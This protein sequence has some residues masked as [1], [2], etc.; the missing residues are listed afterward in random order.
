MAPRT[1][2]NGK[3]VLL[4]LLYAPSVRGEPQ[5]VK[6]RTRLTKMM[7]LFEKEVYDAFRFDCE[8]LREKLPTFY[9]WNY[10][11][12]SRDVYADIDFFVHV[13]FV[14]TTQCSDEQPLREEA[15]EYQLWQSDLDPP[16]STMAVTEYA[17]ELI[18][19][20]DMGRHYVK[21][22]ELWTRLSEN[23]KAALVEFKRRFTEAPLFAILRYVYERYPRMTAK[24]AIREK[25]MGPGSEF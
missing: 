1:A 25:V 18:A 21:Q 2:L 11:P 12:F 17:E 10:G 4:L 13:G 20:T 7:F 19:L 24:S 16:D 14:Q 15:E 22:K 6:G 9:A 3:D 23:Q 5:G 8:I